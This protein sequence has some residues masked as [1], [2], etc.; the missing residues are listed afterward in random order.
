MKTFG[1]SHFAIV[2]RTINYKNSSIY[3]IIFDHAKFR[4]T[5]YV[6]LS[7]EPQHV[8]CLPFWNS[9]KILKEYKVDW[10]LTSLHSYK[11]SWKLRSW[12]KETEWTR[13]REGTF[14]H[15]TRESVDYSLHWNEFF[16]N[17]LGGGVQLGPLGPA[18]TDWLTVPALG[19]YD[20]EEFG[21]MKIGRGNRSTPPQ[22][23]LD[24]T[25]DRTQA[26]AVGTQRLTAWAMARPTLKW[27][28]L[29]YLFYE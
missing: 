25:R 27:N 19:D 7:L 14:L 21:G 15:A 1:S 29:L 13:S 28:R 3:L 5:V 20:D 10:T 23:P 8:A 17:S 12:C 18:A 26:A 2:H 9:L 6:A 22:I 4:D 16:F 11:V 24:Q